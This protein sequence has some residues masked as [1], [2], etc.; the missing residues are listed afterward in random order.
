MT[1]GTCPTCGSVD[2]ALETKATARCNQCGCDF[3]RVGATVAVLS[4]AE[5]DSLAGELREAFG[6]MGDDALPASDVWS[7]KRGEARAPWEGADLEAGS[8]LADFEVLGELG[9]GG[10]GVVYRARQVSLGREVA[11]K[12]LPQVSRHGPA[13]VERF[14]HEAQAAARLNHANVVPIYAQGEHEGHYFYAMKLV[15]GDSLDGVIRSKPHLLSST[16]ANRSSAAMSKLSWHLAPRPS[17]APEAPA[18]T[19]P[20]AETKAPPE[21]AQPPLAQR[22]LADYRHIASLL[23]GVADGL[24][25]AHA[26]GVL[27]R[28]VKPHNLI[29]GNDQRIYITDFG[30]ARLA[31]QPHLTQSGEVMG[32]PSYLS[33]EQARGEIGA[34]DKWTDVY[35]LGVTLYEM[36][37]GRRPF[38]GETREQIIRAVC[39]QEPVRPRKHVRAI[40]RDVET[41]CL[42]AMNKE[43][44]GRYPTALELAEELRRFADGRPI[45]AR[46]ITGLERGIK[47]VRRHKAVSFAA[48]AVL[49]LAVTAASWMVAASASTQQ[50]IDRLVAQAYD[51][52]VHI[53][54]ASSGVA[55][56]LIDEA[57]E[58]GATEDDLHVVRALLAMGRNDFDE[59]VDR[60]DEHLADHP[61]DT[62]ARYM[63]A[64]ALWDRRDFEASRDTVAEA[65]AAGGP[66]SP[67]AWFFRG[68]AVHR[69]DAAAAINAYAI[70]KDAKRAEGAFF[71]QAEL[72]LARAHNQHM[73][74]TRTQEGFEQA[75]ATLEWLI[76][77]GHYEDR[78]FYL[79]TITYRLA[80]EIYSGDTYVRKMDLAEQYYNKAIEVAQRCHE[81]WPTSVRC[82]NAHAL[83]LER[84]GLIEE[85][86][87]RRT[88]AIEHGGANERSHEAYFYRWR[89]NYWLGRFDEAMS[90]VKML[91]SFRVENDY[92]HYAYPALI[93]AATGDKQGAIELTRSIAV[94]YPDQTKPTLL[95][96]SLLRL[97]GRPD[98]ADA[99]LEARRDTTDF[100]KGL[101]APETPAW[102]ESLYDFVAQDVSLASLEAFAMESESPW[103]LLA[104]AYFYAGVVALQRGDEVAAVDQFRK[105]YRTY[106]GDWGTVSVARAL[107]GRLET[108]GGSF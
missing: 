96:A 86:V 71:P 48:A 46:R 61:L 15:R 12:V 51:Q 4:G 24:A 106:R 16:H 58:L 82:H 44:S 2:V 41:I 77:N 11:L 9:R 98:E 36:I 35:S 62:E 57:I 103:E 99:L 85:A 31:D 29:L 22:S 81:A 37:T 83:C 17:G 20:V 64:W 60:L 100:T 1:E 69:D 19:K 38:E 84:M 39:E 93:L 75:R 74:R 94:P 95:S 73:H 91:Q 55:Q 32:T 47:W 102:F 6:L 66:Q 8:R 54:Y 89:L 18:E 104:D 45:R 108:A 105:S 107:L 28:D 97:F 5:A 72:Q 33:P 67:E 27:H 49:A 42:R 53:D 76:N 23:A 80:A 14:R 25:H 79:L 90:D 21:E 70:A 88:L 7:A 87:D 59:A 56:G 13:A 52:L 26:E 78:P 30:L 10:M 65:G 40:P 101:H 3:E 92:Y 34:I 68:L 63:R 43:P 50:E